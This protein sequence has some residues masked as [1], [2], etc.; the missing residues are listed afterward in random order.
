MS[1]VLL[2]GYA[3]DL[4]RVERVTGEVRDAFERAGIEVLGRLAADGA[5]WWHLPREEDEPGTAYDVSAHPFAAEAVWRGL[6]THATPDGPG[7]DDGAG[8]RR[9]WPRPSARARGAGPAHGA[10]GAAEAAWAA[11]LVRRCVAAGRRPRPGPW[12]GCWPG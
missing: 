7:R 8:S 12:R 9:R 10:R 5:R 1:R 6:V 3:D 2:V 4:D 11:G